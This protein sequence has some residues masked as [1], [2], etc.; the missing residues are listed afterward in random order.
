MTR[1]LMPAAVLVVALAVI[2]CGGGAEDATG[3]ADTAG[4]PGPA[5]LSASE[6]CELTAPM[7]CTFYL[8]CDRVVAADE[9]ACRAYFIETCN[10]AYEP[11]YAAMAEL[12]LLRLSTAGLAACADH[13]AQVACDNHLLD[14]DGPCAAVWEG[15]VPA[16]GACAFGLESFV[17]VEDATCVVD[18]SLC[19]TCAAAAAWG[20][21][22]T[23]EVRCPYPGLCLAGT[24]VGP[25]L[26]GQP[27]SAEQRC[28]SGAH[29]VSGVCEP[30]QYVAVGQQCD[31][32]HLCAYGAAC[33][34]GVCRESP[35]LTE[36][37]VGAPPCA[38]GWCDTAAD[39]CTP[40]IPPGAPCSAGAECLTQHCDGGVC[41]PLVSDC[42]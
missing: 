25:A 40:F 21:A 24:C 27:C 3:D 5:Y 35:L 36:Q 2:G 33:V 38:S 34:G 37:C 42:L 20:D 16:G 41:G 30:R 8:R 18:L 22:C 11:R 31:S 28:L 23:D 13:L 10:Q 26:S 15:Q 32:T 1:V 39:R 9:A 12:G 19:G 17:C 7:F 14:L 4:D 6:Y 29:C